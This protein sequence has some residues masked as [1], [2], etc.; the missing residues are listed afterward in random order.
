MFRMTTKKC[1]PARHEK[2]PGE[3]LTGVFSATEPGAARSA[4]RLAVVRLLLGW[5]RIVLGRRVIALLVLLLLIS[6]LTVSLPGDSTASGTQQT[7]DSGTS[8]GT[9]VIDGCP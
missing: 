5:G 3:Y 8:A 7:T 2:N 4:G 6:R 1:S 9:A